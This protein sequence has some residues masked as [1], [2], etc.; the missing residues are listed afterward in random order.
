MS[1][2]IFSAGDDPVFIRRNKDP[3]GWMGNM[4]PFPIQYQG[5][6]YRTTEAL[7]QCMRLADEGAED[8]RVAIRMQ[9]SPM[10]AKMLA[11]KHNKQQ[12]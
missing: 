5:Q 1:P 4:S 6:P 12:I 10:A 11:K 7:F 9:R 2:P 3:Y 8:I